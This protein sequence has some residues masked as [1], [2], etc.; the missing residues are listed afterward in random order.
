M[1]IGRWAITGAVLT[2]ALFMASMVGAQT[3]S[4]SDTK[5]IQKVAEGGLAEVELGKLA[6]EKGGD[7]RIR[8][9][10]Q[11]MA[12]DHGQAGKELEQLATQK[13]VSVGNDMS[14]SHLRERDR[15]A[16]LQPA[17]FDREYVQEMLKDHK[18]D[19]A[20]FR[21]M[22]DKAQDPDLRA[23]ITKTLPTLE[24][25]LKTIES[26]NASLTAQR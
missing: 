11:R 14:S 2:S 24:D 7:Q 21:R 1:R 15:L 26:L 25:H 16:K 17:A 13:G 12:T 19:V 23:W 18:K 20:E 10:G 8:Q 9:F 6:E 4:R 3:V 5:F 22:R